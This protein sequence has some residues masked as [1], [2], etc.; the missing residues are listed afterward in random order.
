MAYLDREFS[1]TELEKLTFPANF[2]GCAFQNCDFSDVDLSG[3]EFEDCQFTDCNLSNLKSRKT[4]LKH[5]EFTDCKLLGFRF[6]S[7]DRFNFSVAFSHCQLDHAVFFQC[8]MP[9]TS[10]S[11]C[12]LLQT[13]FA[14]ADLSESDFDQSDLNGAIFD[15]TDLKGC[16]FTSA[17][18][19]SIDPRNNSLR[20]AKFHP[21]GLSGLLSAFQIEIKY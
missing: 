17:K 18:N 4:A 20:K 15:Q 1:Q 3:S 5:C 8:R 9:R 11:H 13:D 12:R 7:C 16:D 19:F 6:D 10:F 21:S 14:Q 2:D